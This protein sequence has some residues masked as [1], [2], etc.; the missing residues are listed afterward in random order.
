MMKSRKR[1]AGHVAHMGEKRYIDFRWESQKEIDHWEDLD[2][3][4][5]NNI[6]MDLGETRWG[7]MDWIHLAQD[8]TPVESSCEDGNE[9]P[10]SIKC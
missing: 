5:K 9:A 7:S 2:V 6:M 3:G 8:K 1:W 4:G 10:G